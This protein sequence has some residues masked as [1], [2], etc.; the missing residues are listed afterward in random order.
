[1][2]FRFGR[3]AYRPLLFAVILPTF[4]LVP[5][6]PAI[7]QAPR[8]GQ[9]A[10]STGV[11]MTREAIAIL[12]SC[13]TGEQKRDQSCIQVRCTLDQGLRPWTNSDSGHLTGAALHV[14]RRNADLDVSGEIFDNSGNPGHAAVHIVIRGASYT[15]FVSPERFVAWSESHGSDY[16]GRWLNMPLTGLVL[17]GFGFYCGT[18]RATEVALAGRN[19][20]VVRREALNG[21]NCAVVTSQT[22]YGDFTFWIA[23][24]PGN[25]ALRVECVKTAD[26]IFTGT[27]DK[28]LMSAE[29]STE[30]SRMVGWKGVL[31]AVTTRSVAGLHI[32][33]SGRFTETLRFN[34]RATEFVDVY[35]YERDVIGIGPDSEP[36]GA[37]ALGIEAGV[38]VEDF[39]HPNSGIRHFW[40]GSKVAVLTGETPPMAGD[41][42][43]W[44][45]SGRLLTLL[46]VNVG[47]LL[48]L[49]AALYVQRQRQ[50]GAHRPDPPS[51]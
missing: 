31:D 25:P 5:E 9:Q 44:N 40:D 35:R 16:L 3:S 51:A 21:I 29:A 47:L 30:G 39:D 32:P 42:Q 22:P 37:F 14:V 20:R 33:I 15:E 2:R 28:T 50:K 23:D 12:R 43:S 18:Q 4:A 49:G 27:D 36:S 34:T 13:R 11:E 41:S 8:P 7:G 24:L 17:E 6:S 26:H 48:L 1:M 10:P 45:R 38:R 19:Q 46:S